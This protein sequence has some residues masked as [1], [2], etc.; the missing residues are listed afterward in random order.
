MILK[1]QSKFR[2]E[3]DSPV[4]AEFEVC[5]SKGHAGIKVFFQALILLRRGMVVQDKEID[6]DS[7]MIT[8]YAQSSNDVRQETYS[9]V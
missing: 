8:V 2:Q 6:K 5:L 1:Q 7:V 3:C 9:H 4:K